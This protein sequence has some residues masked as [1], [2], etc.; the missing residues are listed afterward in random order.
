MSR[1]VGLPKGKSTAGEVR[2]AIQTKKR[3][4]FEIAGLDFFEPVTFF[5]MG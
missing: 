4:N 1:E 2:E 3:G 5:E